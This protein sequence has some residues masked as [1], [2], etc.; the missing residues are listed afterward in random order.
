MPKSYTKWNSMFLVKLG[1]FFFQKTF[2]HNW[3]LAKC[4][5]YFNSLTH[6]SWKKSKNFD[7][8]KLGSRSRQTGKS[9]LS[10]L[11]RSPVYDPI[12][13][14]GHTTRRVLHVVYVT[15]MI[16]GEKQGKL[17]RCMQF[18]HRLVWPKHL[19]LTRFLLI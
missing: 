7:S 15:I 19:K 5:Y 12:Q 4:I 9:T 6:T 17:S 11:R 14:I 10:A 8:E 18:R 3:L 1:G 13:N 2:W 16:K